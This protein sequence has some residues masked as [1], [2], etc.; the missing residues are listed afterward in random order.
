MAAGSSTL[1]SNETVSLKLPSG[2]MVDAVVPAG[3]SDQQVKLLMQM[4]RP[5]LIAPPSVP[6]PAGATKQAAAANMQPSALGLDYSPAPPGPGKDEY[7]VQNPQALDKNAAMAVG[8]APLGLAAAIPGV[9][10]VARGAIKAA[11]YIAASEGINYARQHLPLGK[12]IPPGSELVPLFMGGGKLAGNAAKEAAGTSAAEA[13]EGAEASGSR[14][15]AGTFTKETP[16]PNPYQFKG[17]PKSMDI[18]QSSNVGKT[19]YDAPTRTMTVEY[20]NGNVYSY[21]GVP[22]EIYN[23]AKDS[24]SIGSYISRN[25]KGRYETVRRGSVLVKK[26]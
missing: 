5:D 11:P 3:Y 2:E 15:P 25:V 26:K 18:E 17:A 16:N 1:P 6:N 23:A 19:G 12:Y 10:A 8:A 24:E 20:K 14:V 7:F 21:H 22:Q 4:K 9:G 13:A